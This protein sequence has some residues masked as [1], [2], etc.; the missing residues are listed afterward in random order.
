MTSE[1]G[2][3]W[4]R[5]RNSKGFS[6]VFVGPGETR[7]PRVTRINGLWRIYYVGHEPGVRSK[8]GYYVRTSDDLVSWSQWRL[9]H[10]DPLHESGAWETECPIVVERG[11]Y[12]YA[13]R[14]EDCLEAKTHVFRSEDQ[15]DFGIGD[16]AYE[17]VGRIAVAAPEIVFGEDGQ[18][19]VGSHHDVVGGTA[20]CRL[21]SRSDRPPVADRQEGAG[22][23]VRE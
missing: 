3:N 16:A 2:R 22:S 1:D 6:R 15:L 19:C 7:D 11:V 20:L 9:A 8:P 10:G 17:Y 13:F 21:G 4:T 23:R 18:E 12:Q 14:V 5:H